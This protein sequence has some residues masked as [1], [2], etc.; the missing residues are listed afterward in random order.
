MPLIKSV[1]LRCKTML[2]AAYGSKANYSDYDYILKW[3]GIVST[4]VNNRFQALGLNFDTQVVV[5]TAV[6]ANTINLAAYQADD[7]LL[8]NLVM[9][10]ST[11]GSSPVEWRLTGQDDLSWQPVPMLGKV[12]DTNT[13]TVPGQVTSDSEQVDSYEWRAGLIWISPCNQIVDLR[14]R[15][16][17][18]PNFASDDAAS[19][20]KGAI[21]VFA[22]WTCE[23]ISGVGPGQEASPVHAWFK[24]RAE[25]ADN[26][27]VCLLAKAQMTEPVR[28]GGRRTQWPGQVGMGAFT[29]PIVG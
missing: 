4:D 17:F 27:F 2:T 24:E 21:N 29:P 15:G 18:L 26:D 11:D 23:A 20:V 7:G 1:A 5:L 3:I 8:A 19:F 13:S 6:P 9:P 14:I 22:Y 25:K 10:D 12:A 16:D 28:L